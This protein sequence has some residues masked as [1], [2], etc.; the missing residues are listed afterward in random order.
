MLAR[1]GFERTHYG[2]LNFFISIIGLIF[3]LI[4]GVL[5]I[6]E[7]V[8]AYKLYSEE[9]VRGKSEFLLWKLSGLFAVLNVCFW[10]CSCVAAYLQMKGRLHKWK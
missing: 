5:I 6:V 3:N 10:G 1:Y 4:A 7:G 8:D 2:G 9:R